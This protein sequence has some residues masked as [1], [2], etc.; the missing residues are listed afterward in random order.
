MSLLLKNRDYTA[1]GKGSV[2]TLSGAEALLGEVLFRLSA[3]RGAFPLLPELGSRMHLLRKEKP[4]SWETLARQ[5]AAE[6]LAGL[7]GVT[8]TGASVTAVG[9]RLNV[10]VSLDRQG[11]TVTVELE[12]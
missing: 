7:E 4:G 3:R 5:Y 8:V 11:E 9:D 10:L 12:G 2:V 6:A 1:D